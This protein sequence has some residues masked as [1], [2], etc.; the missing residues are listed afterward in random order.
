MKKFYSLFLILTA[1][2]FSG[3]VWGEDLTLTVMDDDW[4]KQDVPVDG[5]YLDGAQ[6]NQFLLLSS[7]LSAMNGSNIK[8]LKFY[9]DRTGHSWNNSSIPTV[10]FRLKEVENT[11]LV[12]R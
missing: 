11:L 2:L 3:S 5:Y 10:V 7:E 9:F 6:H 4:Y 8:G 12:V 1:L